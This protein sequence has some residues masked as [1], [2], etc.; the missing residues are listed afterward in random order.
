MNKRK[1][2]AWFVNLTDGWNKEL[3]DVIESRIEAEYRK[4][5]PVDPEKH[6]SVDLDKM[7]E[8]KDRMRG[9]YFGRMT[10]TATLLI[11]FATFLISAAAVVVAIGALF[12]SDPVSGPQPQGSTFLTVLTPIVVALVA[13][14][15]AAFVAED[16]KRF[17]DGK[18]LAA[19][20][21]GE[22]QAHL[23]AFGVGIPNL[24]LIKQHV[25]AG[26]PLKYMPRFKP[27]ADPVYESCVDR[28]G[29]LGPEVARDV[30]YTYQ[31]INA[32]RVEFSRMTKSY[33]KVDTVVL[34]GMFSGIISAA[35]NADERGKKALV[36]LD[37]LARAK[38]RMPRRP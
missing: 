26:R 6:G 17:R 4:C 16:Y 13:A 2:V 12:H 34:V 22:L 33:E 30:A 31:N 5:F 11:G 21:Y 7:I 15:F 1:L 24:K 8:M 25:D 9:F 35:T 32:F 18:S 19:A 28:L 38:Y 29:L 27:P 23:E 20:L 3:H 37:N 36:Q 10:V 14:W